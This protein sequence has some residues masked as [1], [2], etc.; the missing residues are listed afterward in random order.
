MNQMVKPEA[1]LQ[2]VDDVRKELERSRR[3]LSSSAD[4]LRG[5][6]K[7]G[8]TELRRGAHAIKEGFSLKH[9]VA[10]NPWGFVVG[11]IAVGIYLGT[12]DRS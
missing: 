7:E 6:I 4:A 5:E 3:R 8:V 11:A 1:P 12:R 9:W 10:K 2:T